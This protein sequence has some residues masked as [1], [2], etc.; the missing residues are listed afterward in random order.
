MIA[1]FLSRHQI[2]GNRTLY[3]DQRPHVSGTVTRY[4]SPYTL[5]DVLARLFEFSN[6]FIANQ[7]FLAV[8]AKVFGPPATLDKATRAVSDY[9]SEELDIKEIKIV[10]GSGLSRKN[11]VTARA[12]IKV[13]L[14]LLPYRH[15]MQG[16]DSLRYKSGTLLNVSSR[17]G[18]LMKDGR[19]FPF[20]I[21][22][23][24]PGKSAQ[25][26]M[27]LLEKVDFKTIEPNQ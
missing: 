1:H 27:E 15:L 19:I 24:T 26:I 16:N 6:N 14:A 13:L 10:E 2:T 18:Y 17:A 21:L 7:L 8:G 23:N 25:T 20:V 3:I 12:V 22:I 9:L 11:R 5:T 4:H